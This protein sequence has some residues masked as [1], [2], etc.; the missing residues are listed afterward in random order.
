MQGPAKPLFVSSIL[1][2]A[3]FWLMKRIFFVLLFFFFLSHNSF[4]VQKTINLD[5]A[6]SPDYAPFSFVNNG[7]ISGI[8]ID[9]IDEISKRTGIK[10][11]IKQMSFN[12]ILGAIE[13]KKVQIAISGITKNLEREK[14]VSFSDAYYKSHF[15]F[16]GLGDAKNFEKNDK[17]TIAVQSGTTMLEFA[18]KNKEKY[19]IK[20]IIA[21]DN[22]Q[23][24]VEMLLHKKVD[25][26]LIS[27]EFAHSVETKYKDLFI[28]ILK[29]VSDKYAIAMNKNFNYK[30][31]VN[32]AIQ[33]MQKDGTMDDIK[34]KWMNYEDKDNKWDYVIS[35]AWIIGGVLVTIPVSLLAFC[36]GLVFA[37][38]LSLMRYSRKKIWI[39]IAEYYISIIRGT[40]I[41][42]QFSFF[43]FLLPHILNVNLS[44]YS[45]AIITLSINSSAYIAEIIKSG[46]NALD[47]GQLEAAESLN[48]SQQQKIKD[49]ITPQLTQNVAPAML[50]EVISLIKE[51]SVISVFGGYDI[52]KRANIVST[53]YYS[54]FLPMLIAAAT[55]YIIVIG[56][57]NILKYYER[58]RY[59]H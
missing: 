23:I 20:K 37:S 56:L 36:F 59:K 14:I 19:K 7:K 40:P 16:I 28:V 22:N 18:Q 12:S 26:I 10:F 15:A 24:G 9:V 3:S 13:S 39:K 53:Q 25:Y 41:L 44:I 11:S 4:C 29:N 42:L 46:M 48:L 55:Y 47:K 54:Y 8:D 58:R 57:E 38:G 2:L 5:I 52:I 50:N 43:Y 30:K 21:I 1:T 32:K 49:I 17:K 45:S 33:D 27:E 6:T 34:K 31:D 35:L 51:S